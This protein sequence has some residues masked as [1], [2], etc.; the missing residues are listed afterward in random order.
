MKKEDYVNQMNNIYKREFDLRHERE[1]LKNK[2]IKESDIYQQF[3]VGEKVMA[4]IQGKP[5]P[6]FVVG[7]DIPNYS[8][9]E[10]MLSLM[11]CT[12]S[13]K[14][15]KRPLLYVLD[16]GDRIEKIE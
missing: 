10:V 1:A 4:Y 5:V 8:D 16:C 6:A 7:F 12:K 3:K 2:Y 13:G 11:K 14:P 9:N 15:S